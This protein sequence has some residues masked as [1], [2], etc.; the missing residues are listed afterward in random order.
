MGCMESK[1]KIVQ[2]DNGVQRDLTPTISHLH[3]TKSLTYTFN[4]GGLP[5]NCSMPQITVTESYTIGES[6][7]QYV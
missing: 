5:T 7:Q 6:K 2:V 4:Q 1:E 3:G